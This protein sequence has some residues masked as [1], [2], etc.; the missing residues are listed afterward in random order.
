M[1]V[2]TNNGPINLEFI[3]PKKKVV[4]SKYKARIYKSGS[5][6]LGKPCSDI[7]AKLMNK[8]ID[9]LDK[10]IVLPTMVAIDKDEPIKK[11]IYILF[12]KDGKYNLRY[13]TGCTFRVQSTDLISKL[14]IVGRGSLSAEVQEFSF[15][16][17][18]GLKLTIIN[19]PVVENS[20]L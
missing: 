2:L 17:L 12:E 13:E 5:I 14:P 4:A 9:T 10:S 7:I 20:E 19:E 8:S 11:T 15:N 1:T 16:T 18:R 3:E 6:Q